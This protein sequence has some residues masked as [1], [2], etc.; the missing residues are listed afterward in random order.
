MR[1]ETA[2]VDVLHGFLR[3]YLA[4]RSITHVMAEGSSPSA[5]AFAELS[6]L[7]ADVVLTRAETKDMHLIVVGIA[8]SDDAV[9]KMTEQLAGTRFILNPRIA[10]IDPAPANDRFGAGAR[11]FQLEADLRH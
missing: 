6:R 2:E 5:E 1:K 10:R 9:R 11:A 4:R 7:P 3:D 8:R